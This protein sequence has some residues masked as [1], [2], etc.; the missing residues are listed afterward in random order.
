MVRQ[1]AAL[2]AVL[3]GFIMG[4][5]NGVS[6]PLSSVSL[7]F[8]SP[9]QAAVGGMVT[10]SV[11]IANP[12]ERELTL[13][14]RA[15]GA[16]AIDIVVTRAGDGQLI[17]KRYSGNII[18]TGGTLILAPKATRTFTIE[19][20]LRDSQGNFVPAGTYKVVATLMGDDQG[21]VSAPSATLTLR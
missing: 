7:G 6:D 10:F 3:A 4:C 9:P 20:S 15:S 21:S 1:R 5:N 13:P 19:W 18:G 11:T 16:A 14:L 8:S 12:T 2:V 17:W